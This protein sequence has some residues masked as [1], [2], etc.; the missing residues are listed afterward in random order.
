VKRAAILA[1]LLAAPLL[2]LGAATPVAAATPPFT[3][4]PAIGADTSCQVL[5][6]INPNGSPTIDTDPGQGP[7]D[8]IEDALIG[9][10]NSSGQTIASLPI[11]GPGIFGLD[12]DGLCTASGAPAGCPFGPTRYEGP[13]TSFTIADPSDG[14]VTFAGG[15]AP[16]ASAYFSLEGRINGSSLVIDSFIQAQP[17]NFTVVEG[18]S[19]SGTVA[20]FTD[21]DTAATASEYAATINWGDG[22]PVAT[23]VV[24]GGGGSFMVS[25]SHTYA[26]EGSNTV[27]VTVT[28]V[29]NSSNTA[30]STATS[31]ISDAALTATCA[32]PATSGQAFTGQTATFT[33]AASPSGTL[34]DFSATI[35]WGDSSSSAG[36]VSGP[37]GGPY[38]I[39]GTHT[40]AT[41]GTFTITT[42]VADVGG[43]SASSTCSVLVFAFAPG[44]GAFAIGD[45]NSA[46]GSA[47]TFWSADWNMDNTVSD[48]SVSSFKGFAQSPATPTCGTTFSVTTGNSPPPPPGPLPAF[49]GVIVTS[50]VSQSGSIDSGPVVHLVVVQTNPDYQPSPGHTGTGT[51]VAV[52]C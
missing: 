35:N 12:G 22:S 44:G 7:F 45:G 10:Q 8:G 26:E 40:Y 6:T 36:T 1:V 46:V 32:A 4:C 15:L 24:G 19:F 28:D 37:N 27:T 18:Q 30:T 14:T 25:G 23:G 9:V 31:T 34:S 29:D 50:K 43:S 41:T 5:I 33:D 49:M 13:H 17:A 11:S 47:V 42:S 39:S 3:Q 48:G 20:T 2:S 52:I 21:A 51:V 38:A 16:G